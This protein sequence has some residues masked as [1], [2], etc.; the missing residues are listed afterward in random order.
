MTIF[1]NIYFSSYLLVIVYKLSKYKKIYIIL[2]SYPVNHEKTYIAMYY[3][4]LKST[5]FRTT[6]LQ[7]HWKCRK[8][9]DG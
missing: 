9:I 2:N 1:V 3:R 7:G 8:C 5:R 6:G 4:A